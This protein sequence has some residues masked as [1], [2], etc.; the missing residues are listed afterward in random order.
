[1]QPCLKP[2]ET[3]KVERRETQHV[4]KAE[5]RRDK[6][7]MACLINTDINPSP[8]WLAEQL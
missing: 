1:M 8:S 2:R 5:V 6:R 7:I 4:G 3:R